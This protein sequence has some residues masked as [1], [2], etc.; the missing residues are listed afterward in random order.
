MLA[1]MYDVGS[2][3]QSTVLLSVREKCSREQIKKSITFG[4]YRICAD[5]MGLGSSCSTKEIISLSGKKDSSY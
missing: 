3:C 4:L 5:L 1:L 2:E